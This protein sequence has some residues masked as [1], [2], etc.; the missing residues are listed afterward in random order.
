MDKLELF[1]R[2]LQTQK[3]YSIHTIEAYLLDLKQFKEF[4]SFQYEMDLQEPFAVLHIRSW[5]A[6][7]GKSGLDNRSIRRKLSSLNHFCKF[8]MKRN[9][10]DENPML[11][12]VAPKL[13]KR[14]PVVLR[15][16]DLNLDPETDLSI[17]SYKECLMETI[18]W[19]F[20]GLGLRRNE[21]VELKLSDVHFKAGQLK[22]LGK[23][24]KERILPFG[25]ELAQIFLRYLKVRSEFKVPETDYFFVLQ[26]GKKVYPK[27]VYLLVNSWL[28]TR[29]SITKKS[30]HVLRHS[31]ATHVSNRG[32][33]IYAIKELLGHS[34]LAAT[35][36][37][38][39]SSIEQLKKAYR[40]A[41]PR[42]GN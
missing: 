38:T 26:N 41:H 5:I 13:K 4:L 7:M 8:L 12:L 10:L 42:A 19:T 27:M 40:L 14:L 37:Y 25:N 31:F 28:K 30:P 1:S 36:I 20:Y 21:L 34:S 23:G 17:L 39:H 3:K 35:Q 9:L 15:E 24:N 6:A 18:A 2:Y 33:D 29:T 11:K 16:Q 32:A 22:V